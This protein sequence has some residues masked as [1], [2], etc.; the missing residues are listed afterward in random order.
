MGCRSIP[1]FSAMVADATTPGV[2][3]LLDLVKGLVSAFVSGPVPWRLSLEDS[4]FLSCT[5]GD[6]FQ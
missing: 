4:G 1:S 3:F 6:G 5:M 2:S